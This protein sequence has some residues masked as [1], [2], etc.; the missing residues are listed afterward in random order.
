VYRPRPRLRSSSPF[1]DPS[2]QICPRPRIQNALPICPARP[3]IEGTVS[4]PAVLPPHYILHRPN[5]PSRQQPALTKASSLSPSSLLIHLHLLPSKPHILDTRY[6]QSAREL[7]D[8]LLS[9]P[10]PIRAI[11]TRSTV[12]L[13]L[14]E[15]TPI[16]YALNNL[17][18]CPQEVV[19]ACG[20][21]ARWS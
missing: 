18:F 19:Q 9:L 1:H 6:R 12:S 15:A 4:E 11:A 7:T 2:L 16:L 14:A 21:R 8:F 13:T 10:L 20:D 3:N 5:E 17:C